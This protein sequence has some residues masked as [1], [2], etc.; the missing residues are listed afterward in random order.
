[1]PESLRSGIFNYR[2]IVE[3]IRLSDNPQEGYLFYIMAIKPIQ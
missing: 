2:E 3:N 1:M